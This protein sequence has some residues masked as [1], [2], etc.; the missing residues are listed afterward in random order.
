VKKGFNQTVVVSNFDK[1]LLVEQI[2]YMETEHP[3]VC[4]TED[5]LWLRAQ[6]LVEQHNL[7]MMLGRAARLSRYVKT[8]VFIVAAL[9][10][11]LGSVYAITD[12]HTINIYWLLLIL[13]GFNLLS[14]LLWLTTVI[15][16]AL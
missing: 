5:R 7:S 3:L 4:D 11:A 12:S 10:G 13:L 15:F 6:C 2:R 9:L 1:H 8:L 14:M 16:P